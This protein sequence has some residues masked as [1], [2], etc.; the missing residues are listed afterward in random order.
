MEDEW[1]A[2]QFDAAALTLGGR[3]QRALEANGAQKKNLRRPA[4]V[5]VR[6]ILEEKPE[7]KG[8]ERSRAGF[9]DPRPFVSR[10]VRIPE[11][12]IW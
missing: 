6:E 11:S 10:K 4:E 3:I 7:A 9:R 1:A 12:G 2:Y 8:T 5:I